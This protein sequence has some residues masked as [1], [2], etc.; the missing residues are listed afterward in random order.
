[1]PTPHEGQALPT[2]SD[3]EP[4]VPHAYT[5]RHTIY[6]CLEHPGTKTSQQE[7][8]ENH[9]LMA[10]NMVEQVISG[11]GQAWSEESLVAYLDQLNEKLPANSTGRVSSKKKKVNDQLDH[12]HASRHSSR[13]SEP[14]SKVHMGKVDVE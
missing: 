4:Y 12:L 2:K 10:A 7:V 13:D 9:C 5:C 1:M 8:E 14:L 6:P 3:W 11:T